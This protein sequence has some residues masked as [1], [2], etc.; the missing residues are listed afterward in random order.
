MALTALIVAFVFAAA[1]FDVRSGIIPRQLSLFGLISGLLFHAFAGGLLS[2]VTAAIIG[3][4]VGLTFFQLGAIGGGDV[5]L[6]TALGALLGLRSWVVAMEVAVMMAALM[7]LAEVT[8]RG[9]LRR[10]CRNIFE[11]CKS[12]YNF[13]FKAH[14]HINV[15]N[16]SM[17]RTPFGVAAACGTVF[18]IWVARFWV[19]P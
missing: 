11:I 19:A 14:P 13:G 8:R 2:A 17:V 12:I 4:A 1:L 7:A 6:I 10:T 16:L 15:N 3:F 18:A 5:K 9:L